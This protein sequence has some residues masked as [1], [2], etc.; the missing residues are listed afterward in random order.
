V[1]VRRL[2]GLV[3]LGLGGGA[4]LG[5]GLEDGLGLGKLLP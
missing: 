3:A 4:L 1:Q 2:G 5:A